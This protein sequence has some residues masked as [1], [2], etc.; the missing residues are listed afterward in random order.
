MRLDEPFP[1]EAGPSRL[2]N[3]ILREFQGRCPSI[4][5]MAQIPD[6]Q[7]LSTPDVGPRSVEIIHDLTD[8][9]GQ[10][11]IRPPDAQLTDAE[12]LERLEWLQKEVR[13]LQDVLKARIFKE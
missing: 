11:T 9:A 3:A 5:E 10:Q 8:A 6:R 4:R 2:R 7:W 12:L 13:W 1:W